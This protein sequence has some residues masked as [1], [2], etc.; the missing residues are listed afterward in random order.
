[1][2][3]P[4]GVLPKVQAMLRSRHVIR[5]VDGPRGLLEALPAM[6]VRIRF[7]SHGR[8]A[9]AEVTGTHRTIAAGEGRRSEKMRAALHLA[10]VVER[11]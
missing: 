5:C 9:I 6:L 1:M 8:G 11:A 7:E 3:A 2:C 4:D 10:C